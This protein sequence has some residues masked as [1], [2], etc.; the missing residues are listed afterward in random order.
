M[1]GQFKITNS[2]R[3]HRPGSGRGAHAVE[4]SKTAVPLGEGG[5]F[6]WA[7]PRVGKPAGRTGQ[8]S[9]ALPE[10]KTPSR[11]RRHLLTETIST[12]TADASIPLRAAQPH[13]AP[14]AHADDLA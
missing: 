12:R 14:L 11:S 3:T 6:L 9:A 10:D 7:R 5:S 8:Y 2:G 1:T 4:F 13:E